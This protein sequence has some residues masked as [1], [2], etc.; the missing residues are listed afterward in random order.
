[1][2][3]KDKQMKVS[4]VIPAFNEERYIGNTLESLKDLDINDWEV[5]ILVINGGSTD[6]TRDTARNLGARVIDV[7]HKGIG[8]ARQEGIKHAKGDIVAFTDADTT[9]PKDWLTR[10]IR[11]LQKPG[12]VFTYGTFRVSDGKFPYYHY[13][14]Y[15]QPHWLWWVHHFL[16]KPIAAGQ[17]LSFWRDKA[18][19]IGG[20]NDKISLFEDI[21]FAIRMRKVGKVVFLQDL[22]VNSSGR[23]SKEGWKFFMRMTY[24]T[25]RYFILGNRTLSGFPDFR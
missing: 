9:V 16:R 22:V 2:Q 20:F 17:N 5:E 3:L 18:F 15:I 24:E 14:N 11:A 1:M 21:D 19:K 6:K 25:L 13:I 23:R 8:F 4:I 12:V 10:H 7:P